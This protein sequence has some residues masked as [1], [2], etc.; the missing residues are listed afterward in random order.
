MAHGK[1]NRIAAATLTAAAILG[2]GVIVAAPASAATINV[3]CP[4]RPTWANGVE[5]WQNTGR[6]YCFA[7]N[8]SGAYTRVNTD[9]DGIQDSTSGWNYASIWWL[10]NDAPW[11]I[12]PGQSLHMKN[13][14]VT[15]LGVEIHGAPQ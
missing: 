13:G 12:A 2:G 7:D 4:A 5:L 11:Q 10:G 6:N 9:Y 14:N 1:T 3:D 8:G 15:V